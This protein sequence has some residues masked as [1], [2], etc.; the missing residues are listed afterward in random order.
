MA[1]VNEKGGAKRS[2]RVGPAPVPVPMSASPEQAFPALPAPFA[3]PLQ[4]AA[5][6][7]VESDSHLP[8]PIAAGIDQGSE[9]M[10]T[11]A[12]PADAAQE[13]LDRAQAAFGD[14]QGRMTAAFDRSNRLGEE[15]A[16]FARGNVEAMLASARAAAKAGEALGAEMADYGRKSMESAT[17]AFKGFAAVKSP[18]ELFQLQS[19]YAKASFD[20]AVAEASKLSETVMKHAG[21]IAQPISNRYAL[22]AEKVRTVAA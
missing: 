3:D 13:T 10:A 1:D 16:D 2:R 4:A 22:A 20:S 17:A 11:I 7:A 15:M 21:E 6:P 5:S 12:S 19:D 14:V 18:T 9:D 8:G